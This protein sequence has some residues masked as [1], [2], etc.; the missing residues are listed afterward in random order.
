VGILESKKIKLES[1]NDSM[2]TEVA[3]MEKKM[4]RMK[5]GDLK[6]MRFEEFF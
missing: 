3:Q 5:A 1:E 4:A 2:M 6:F